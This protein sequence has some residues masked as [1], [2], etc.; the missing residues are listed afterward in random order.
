MA[1]DINVLFY[2]IIICIYCI[3]NYSEQNLI[4]IDKYVWL[5]FLVFLCRNVGVAD[6]WKFCN[7]LPFLILAFNL[8]LYNL[9]SDEVVNG[10]HFHDYLSPL[11]LVFNLLLLL[12][13]GYHVS[14]EQFPFFNFAQVTCSLVRSLVVVSQDSFNLMLVQLL[15]Q[16][17]PWI[18][19]LHEYL[20]CALLD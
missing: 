16:V 5:D 18:S 10:H 2:L 19:T 3:F 13:L 15:V 9:R 11:L 20:S 14:C 8:V 17:F 4:I 12:L 1:F 6:V 7:F